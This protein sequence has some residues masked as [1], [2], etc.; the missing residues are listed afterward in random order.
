ML[1]P[2]RCPLAMAGKTAVLVGRVHGVFTHVPLAVASR[3]WK[4]IDPESPFWLSVLETT[5][6]PTLLAPPARTPTAAPAAGGAPAA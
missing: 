2:S 4:R 5:G 6:Q 3:A 1:W